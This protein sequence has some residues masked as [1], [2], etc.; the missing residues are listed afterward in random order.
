MVVDIAGGEAA[1]GL[2]C[3]ALQVAAPVAGLAASTS[4]RL[5]SNTSG[6]WPACG[7][8]KTCAS[9]PGVKASL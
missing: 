4:V 3:L 7:R 8:W 9:N 2:E 1:I 5:G 6:G